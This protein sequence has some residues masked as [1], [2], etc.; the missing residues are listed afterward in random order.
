MGVG[1]SEQAS[2]RVWDILKFFKDLRGR[3]QNNAISVIETE[4][5]KGIDQSF[6]REGEGWV[7][8]DERRFRNGKR[9]F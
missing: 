2:S 9:Q 5:N 1:M 6:C 8:G 3:S 7:G 4:F